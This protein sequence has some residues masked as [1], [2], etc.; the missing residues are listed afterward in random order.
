MPVAGIPARVEHGLFKHPACRGQGRLPLSPFPAN[1]TRKIDA[2]RLAPR[3]HSDL[4]AAGR[5]IPALPARSLP[6]QAGADSRRKRHLNLQPPA[7][8]AILRP[9]Q[10]Q[11]VTFDTHAFVKRLTRTGMPED[12]AEVLANG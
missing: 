4:P 1:T 3:C 9:I 10:T 5:W 7:S 11:A 6:E 8:T 12:Q 2:L